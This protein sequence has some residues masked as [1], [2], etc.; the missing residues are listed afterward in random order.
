MKQLFLLLFTWIILPVNAQGKWNYS[1]HGKLMEL[2]G[3]EYV[4]SS[5]K[6]Y[7]KLSGKD[8]NLLFINTLTGKIKEVTFS[9]NRFINNVEHVKI[10]SLGINKVIIKVSNIGN[11]LV[12]FAPY[13]ITIASVDG[14]TT[15]QI[16][17]PNFFVDS[18]IVNK[19]T[20]IIV[21]TGYEDTNNNM[22]YDKSD[23]P[24]ILLYS[25]KEMKMMNIQ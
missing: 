2:E 20:G 17:N 25:L 23:V 18:Y 10:D 9:K 21:I 16:T 5:S 15:E 22:K 7:S 11:K 8:E 1:T 19:H 14:S 24:Q 3:T 4:I 13:Q 6:N 12:W